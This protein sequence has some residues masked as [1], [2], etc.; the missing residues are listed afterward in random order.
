MIEPA[1][2]AFNEQTAA[3]NAMQRPG[4]GGMDTGAVMAAARAESQQLRRAL[5][6]EGVR[7]RM[8]M[9]TTVP[10]KPDALF[11]NNWISFHDDGTIVLYPMLAP[12]RRL[13]RRTELID[14]V[15]AALD[16]HTRRRLDFHCPCNDG[17]ERGRELRPEHMELR[18]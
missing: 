1:C 10:C 7:V 9:D 12:N 8:G 17:G 3:S 15:C 5:E 11:P 16:F 4:A 2:F 14:E 18:R 6:S 13:E